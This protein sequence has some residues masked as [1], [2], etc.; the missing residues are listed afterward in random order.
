MPKRKRRESIWVRVSPE[1]KDALVADANLRNSN[2]TDVATEI[3]ARHY[4]VPWEP[5]SGRRAQIGESTEI[6]LKM[7]T[8]LAR[9]ID[10]VAWRGKRPK[11]D[12]V[13]EILS[14]HY[15]IVFVPSGSRYQGGRP[16]EAVEA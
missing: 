14:K 15:E 7:P 11:S 16:S 5:C 6:L 13:R 4:G 12:V 9:K 3:L 8:A 2:M 10:E 1:L